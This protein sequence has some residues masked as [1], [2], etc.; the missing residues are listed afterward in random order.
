MRRRK[1]RG[2]EDM[3]HL[4]L[5]R[6]PCLPYASCYIWSLDKASLMKGHLCKDLKEVWEQSR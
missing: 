1:N 4:A 6:G 5:A 2:K 3:D